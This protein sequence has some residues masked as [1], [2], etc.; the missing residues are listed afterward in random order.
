M[1][2]NRKDI[3]MDLICFNGNLLTLQNELSQY[4]WDVEEPILIISK[5]E[6]SDVL[7]RCVEDEISFE[8]L[9]NWAN[10]IECRD[11]LDFKGVEM[12][13]IIFELASPEVNGEIRK[14][15][16]QEIIDELQKQSPI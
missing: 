7:K 2:R 1:M 15:R 9:E 16:L 12:Q 8:E 13:E 11:D 6:L 14:E 3:L 5:V 4:F 10:A